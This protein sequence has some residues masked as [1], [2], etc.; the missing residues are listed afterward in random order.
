[1][2]ELKAY[3]REQQLT[4]VVRA[5]R[6]A[7]ATAV[8]VVRTV[9]MGA[10][11]EPEYVDVSRAVSLQHFT[12]MLK[13]ELVCDDGHVDRYVDLIRDRAR[14]GECGDGVVFV[15]PIEDAVRIRNGERGER[16][17]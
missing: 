10:E 17:L 8:T 15:S 3:I 1:M 13:L 14:T 9:P 2:K 4:E 16:A 11:V 12:P 6:T 5:L 7:G